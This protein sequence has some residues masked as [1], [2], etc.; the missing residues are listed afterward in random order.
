M[1]LVEVMRAAAKVLFRG[2]H[3]ATGH[4][5]FAEQFVIPVDQLGLP[6]CGIQLAGSEGIP[7]CAG[8]TPTPTRSDRTGGNKDDF[9]AFPM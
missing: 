5:M 9:H 3:L 6:D 8:I 1:F 4:A 2:E 7:I